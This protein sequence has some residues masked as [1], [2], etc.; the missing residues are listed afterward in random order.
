[1]ETFGQLLRRLRTQRGETLA[2]VAEN[3][4]RGDGDG[5]A[6]VSIPMLSRI[7]TDD[8]YPSTR[9]AV[10][11]AAYY[12]V[13]ADEAIVILTESQA[14][15]K[16]SSLSEMER[17]AQPLPRLSAARI[18]SDQPQ[19]ASARLEQTSAQRLNVAGLAAD[20]TGADRTAAQNAGV[21]LELAAQQLIHLM[22]DGA[23]PPRV[24]EEL[25]NRA[26]FVAGMLDAAAGRRR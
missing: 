24:R 26:A 19:E 18:E 7:E 10:A 11:I 16:W 1:M 9:V 2:Q 23:L 25:A 14:H 20:R 3:L 6:R 22:E 21:M 12:G 13:P 15:R 5:G 17:G 4:S 8:R